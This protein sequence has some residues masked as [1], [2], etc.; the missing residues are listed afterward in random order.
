MEPVAPG[1]LEFDFRERG[2]KDWL[3]RIE[4]DV[5]SFDP[6]TEFNFRVKLVEFHIDIG[7]VRVDENRITGGEDVPTWNN[8]FDD[9]GSFIAPGAPPANEFNNR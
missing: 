7:S 4:F 3:P 1:I 2:F 6:A 9:N 8:D 5:P